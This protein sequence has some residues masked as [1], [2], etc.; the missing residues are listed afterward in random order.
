MI[1]ILLSYH[2]QISDTK[3]A[4]YTFGRKTNNLRNVCCKELLRHNFLL[5]SEPYWIHH[6]KVINVELGV[7]NQRPQKFPSTEFHL[8]QEIFCI[9]VS[10]TP[11]IRHSPKKGFLAHFFDSS[12]T[13]ISH[14]FWF[15]RDVINNILTIAKG[16]AENGILA[17]IFAYSII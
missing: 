15:K 4:I 6:S 16:L 1:I 3:T 14:V 7:R 2:D 8:N 5:F 17:K 13:I 11:A 10:Y 12:R 9:Q